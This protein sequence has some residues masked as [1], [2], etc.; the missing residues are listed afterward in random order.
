MRHGPRLS[1][2]MTATLRPLAAFALLGWSPAFAQTICHDPPPGMSCPGDRL[3]WVNTPSGVYHFKGQRYFGCTKT[4]K[5]LCQHDAD[6]EGD[7]RRAM[8]N[9]V[10]PRRPAP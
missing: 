1:D 10:A 3:V 7:R 9:S 4:G 2:V 8:G 6:L 5:F